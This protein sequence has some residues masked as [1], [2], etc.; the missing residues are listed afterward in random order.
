MDKSKKTTEKPK[1]PFPVVPTTKILATGLA[2]N[3]ASD[4]STIYYKDATELATLIGGSGNS[5][6]RLAAI[7]SPCRL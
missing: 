7:G 4:A 5:L 6:S 3:A 1:R 2:S